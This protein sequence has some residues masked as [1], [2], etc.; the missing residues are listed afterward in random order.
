MNWDDTK[1]EGERQPA[2]ASLMVYVYGPRD[3]R[4]GL[5]VFIWWGCLELW[6]TGRTLRTAAR[7]KQ[8]SSRVS[9]SFSI[10]TLTP[11]YPLT[12]SFQS[13]QQPLLLLLLQQQQKQQQKQQQRQ[14]QA[15]CYLLA[16][17]PCM[18]ACSSVSFRFLVCRHYIIAYLE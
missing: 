13:Q 16:S 14:R 1:A 15:I 7:E 12:V 3:K 9:V 10:N 5:G 2:A 4:E 6:C 17:Y 18:F 8:K 11:L